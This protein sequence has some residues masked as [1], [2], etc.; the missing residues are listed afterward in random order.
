M[1]HAAIAVLVTS[2]L[3]ALALQYYKPAHPRSMLG[4]AAL[5]VLGVPLMILGEGAEWP[6]WFE[7]WPTPLRILIRLVL[8]AALFGVLCGL[9]LV[10]TRLISL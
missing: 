9:Y 5:I 6:N 3:T 1:R 4:W 8:L 7:A 2:L 10:A